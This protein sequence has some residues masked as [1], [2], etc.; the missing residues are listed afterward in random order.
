VK[1]GA[2]RVEVGDKLSYTDD[3]DSELL[4]R[5]LNFR[6]YDE[7]TVEGLYQNAEREEKGRNY[8]LALQKY[9]EVLKRE[10]LHM[11]ALTR[12]AEMYCR[13][14]E[15]GKALEFARKALDYV[16][17]DPDANYIY[18]VIA[19]RTGKLVDAKE[20]L[21]WAARSMKYR[22]SANCQLGEIYLMER[23]HTRALEF[24][25][26]ALDYDAHNIK[27]Q[28]VLSTAFRMLKSP[29]RAAA[30]LTRILDADPLNHTARFE[31][32]LLD[33]SADRL[34]EFKELIRNELPHETYLEIAMY[35]VSLGLNEDA[36]RVLEQAPEQATVRYWQAY[37]LREKAPER[38]REAL[39]RAAALSPY[40]VFP[41]REESIPVFQWADRELPGSWKAKYYLGL[42][43]W[44][45]RR[46][47]EA[48]KMLDDLRDRPDYAPAYICRAWLEKESSPDRAL[49][50]FER[51]HA[52]GPKDWRNWHH[53]AAYYAERGMHDRSMKLAIEA[54][55]LFPNE[56]LIKI[57]LARAY[58]NNGRYQESYSVLENA[59]ILPF[60]G[61]RDVHE[62]YVLCQMS[63][64]L[65]AMKKGQFQDAVKRLEG[66]KEYPVRL[67][68]GKPNDPDFRVQDVLISLAYSR[69]GDAGKA[70]EADRRAGAWAS[71]H[72]REQVDKAKVDQWYRTSLASK[73]E[74]EALREL[75]TL[76]RGT[77][78]RRE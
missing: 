61:Q 9:L 8:D 69:L 76:V 7:D 43:Y 26:R 38:S 57:L 24:L 4:D 53:L 28:Q 25:Q 3:P 40:L 31:R 15:Y 77:R 30:M 73:P 5:P 29:E 47:P 45:L 75:V 14:A 51:A 13:R 64:A 12:T 49:A 23:N 10:P 20:S 71:R 39:G 50:D 16:M 42:V 52:V 60:E 72:S 17:Y 32:Y 62:L 6:N 11:R 63:L 56:D 35:Y 67:G 55:R 65:E 68:T 66:S 34:R 59:T 18:S 19:R 44:G 22:T 33:P 46:Q 27:A 21:G 58:L 36:L 78:P 2:L 41:F 54:S 70:E 48:L 37:L 74:L 1:K